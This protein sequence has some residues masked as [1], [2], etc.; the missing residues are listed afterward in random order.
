MYDTY[1]SILIITIITI[2]IWLS[3]LHQRERERDTS[4]MH[5][6]VLSMLQHLNL[7]AMAPCSASFS[8]RICWTSDH[9]FIVCCQWKSQCLCK[10]VCMASNAATLKIFMAEAWQNQ[11]VA[12]LWAYSLAAALR[13]FSWDA[14][15]FSK[16]NVLFIWYDYKLWDVWFV[17]QNYWI[18]FHRSSIDFPFHC[19]NMF[20]PEDTWSHGQLS[21]ADTGLSMTCQKTA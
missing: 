10:I 5:L 16:S 6:S 7:Q 9:S 14:M 18:C 15:M 19:G 21:G 12:I 3:K 1:L 11:L 13:I 8:R 2:D 17:I 4:N 20:Q